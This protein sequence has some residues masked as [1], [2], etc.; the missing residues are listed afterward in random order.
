MQ[1]LDLSTNDGLRM[2]CEAVE[3]NDPRTEWRQNIYQYLEQ[4]SD[5]LPDHFASERFHRLLWGTDENQL[6]TQH[7]PKGVEDAIADA[8]FREWFRNCLDGFS[9]ASWD[10]EELLQLARRVSE[11][12]GAYGIHSNFFTAYRGL[13]ALYPS[14]MSTV[15]SR[16]VLKELAAKM[17]IRA[18]DH[19][20][21]DRE[22]LE[23]VKNVLNA[24]NPDDMT[25][26]IRRMTLP[27]MLY[28]RY[29]RNA[30]NGE[31]AEQDNPV[32]GPLFSVIS[33]EVDSA[34]YFPI[35][36]CRKLHLGL[37]CDERR[38]FAILTGLS[39][40]GKTLL[41]RAYGKA[42]SGED[43]APQCCVI[44]VQPGWTDP[45]FLFGYTNPLQDEKYERTEFL[46]VLLSANANPSAPHVV[47]LDEMNLS[48]PEQY[49]APVLS[50]METG[51]EVMLHG[52]E[53]KV[54]GVPRFIPYP[55]NL[56]LI[57][58]V[59]MDE[60]TMGLSDKVLDRAFT[61]EFWNISID[62]WPEW[63]TIQ[64]QADGAKKVKAVLND[65]MAALSPAR[66]HFGY[67]SIKEVVSFLEQRERQMPEW[68][69]GDA[70]DS[71]IYAKILPKLRGD[72]SK[73]VRTALG[74]CRDVL[75]K[76][77]L[78]SSASK[79]DELIEDLETTGSA[80]FWR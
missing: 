68:S 67:R 75:K 47:I 48:H 14:H 76:H 43:A 34:G 44:P 17:N 57:G 29:V 70:L 61:L 69:F 55:A 21:R 4:V 49:L 32:G 38:H 77:G 51:N 7:W 53:D 2:A 8:E 63:E 25:Q 26:V 27:M 59:N 13:A 3:L 33:A 60:T 35:E 24:A 12:F 54:D 80:R 72:A 39:G 15:A 58:T 42:L 50:A 78:E 31:D 56:F 36:L 30:P 20:R 74:S 37:S 22:V 41:A 9:S 64:L 73:P 1:E 71:V 52:R 18:N 45:S 66:L 46:E 6:S 65:L 62:K 28:D 11:R 40:S 5:T 16:E 19:A 10:I 23:R 79:V